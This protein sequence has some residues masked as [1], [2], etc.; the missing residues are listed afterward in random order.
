MKMARLASLLAAVLA[1]AAPAALAQSQQ[2]VLSVNMTE[3]DLNGFPEFGS[4]PAWGTF[5]VFPDVNGG[6]GPYTDQVTMWALATGT[7]PASGFTYT[8]YV[9]GTVIGSAILTV[10]TVLP[11]G[12]P[13]PAYPYPQAVSWTPPQPGTYYFSVQA[14]DGSHTA[15]SLAVEY[16]A[17]GIS[18]VSPVAN[19]ILPLGSSV[20]I[21]AAAAIAS[22]AVSKV[23]FYADGQLLG[24]SSNYPYSIIYTPDPTLPAGTVHFIKAQSFDADGVTVAA[25]TPLQGIVSVAPVT[26]LPRCSIGSPAQTTPPTTIP[27]P[28]YI[29]DPNAFIP[30]TVNASSAGTITKVELYING[31]LYGT[32]NALPYNF[33]WSPT[34]GGTFNLTALA[35]DAKNNVIAST[36]STTSTLTPAPTT[37]IVGSLPSVAIT[38]PNNGST[39]SGGSVTAITAT[40]TDNNVDASGN[41]IAISQVQFYQ[42]GGVVGT[43]PGIAGVSV[44]T[45]TF[46]PVQKI[47]SSTGLAEDSSLTAIATD[48]LG[49]QGVSP[50][51]TVSV[52]AG[53]SSGSTI[54]G[55]PPTVSL[56]Q[57]ANQANVYVNTNVTLSASAN[58]PNG[59]VA[60]V[61]FLVDSVVLDTAS[62]YP[63]SVTWTPTNL[64]FYTITA[65]VI[66]NLGDKTNSAQITVNVV[67]PPAPT[68][69]VTSPAPGGIL[70]VGTPVSIT[71][72]ASSPAGTIAQVQFFENGV[73]IGT[74][75]TSP[76]SISFTPVSTG[77]YTLT[78][79]ATD[80]SGLVTSSNSVVVEAAPSTGGV[81]TTTYFGQ[82]VGLS[83]ADQ[84]YFAMVVA[85]GVSGTYITLP[86]TGSSGISFVP[87]IKVTSA[88][89]LSSTRITGTAS[90][91]GISGNLLPGNETYI[92][93]VPVAG[94]WGV[95]S[96]YYLGSLVGQAKSDVA[97]IVG[98]DGEIMVYVANG[99]YSDAAYGAPGSVGSDGSFAV[100]TAGN[101]YLSGTVDPSR[102]L[103]NA[104]LS[105]TSG[106]TILGAKVT[107][108][109]F[110]DGTL[111]NISTRGD[112]GAGA[113][114]M[115]AG[116]VVNGTTP[117]NLLIRAVGP[118]LL[119][120]GLTGALATTQLS[121][122]QGSSLIAT[123]TGWS[124]TTANAYAVAS[125]EITCGAFALIN[126]SADSALVGTFAPGAYTAT[127][128][129]TGGNTGVA[130]VEAYDLDV[131]APFTPNKLVN[132]STRGNVGSGADILIGGLVING[133]TPKKVLIRGAGPSLGALGVPGSLATPRL[134]IYD[135]TGTLI[136]ENYAWGNGN[137]PGLVSAAEKA[138]GAFAFASGSADSAILVVLNPGTYTVQVSGAGSATG[139][140][141][142][143]VYEVD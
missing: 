83:T 86:Y 136:R 30:V 68:V 59:N 138:S 37:V 82:Y 114:E 98:P 135:S 43:A 4:N 124:S 104:S 33:E 123:N 139:I 133:S 130:L 53:G 65:Q 48:A 66:D 38:S 76:Y 120:Y 73:S 56:T 112:V 10:P 74:V 78:A 89:S 3:I 35:Y 50:A 94:A 119:N 47:N 32:Q 88:G 2:P 80:N 107:G 34:V 137:D 41:P 131:Y 102:A 23:A 128:T 31:V 72:N 81:N 129:G 20:V 97:A 69:S 71:A 12:T 6:S 21:Q 105:G 18:I 26:P 29:A 39:L 17:T 103:L 11:P 44:Y 90:A 70:T 87:D 63:Y 143:E 106:G 14:S 61:S 40:A 25:T 62:K 85:D 36:T 55:T 121:V 95:A 5:G 99:T 79:V 24:Y 42:D 54:V 22:G 1:A 126:G 113:D 118:G 127:V 100:T 116:F 19:A 111:R 110:S 134:Q 28:D 46:T 57:P 60:S 109:V 13:P 108:G 140:A 91:L 96:G 51:V 101:N 52:T 8:F 7:S 27:I 75:T 77:L 15:N 9:N 49:F 64:G 125:A 16:F 58:A 45:I 115:I 93:G 84:G 67:A 122:Y 132:V 142:V 117:K 141:L 92:A